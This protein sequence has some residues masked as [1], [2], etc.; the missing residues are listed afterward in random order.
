MTEKFEQIVSEGHEPFIE[1]EEFDI[2]FG[3]FIGDPIA[4]ISMLRVNYLDEYPEHTEEMAMD[5]INE[6][7]GYLDHASATMPGVDSHPILG[8]Y[9]A[10][11]TD[12]QT[13]LHERTTCIFNTLKSAGFTFEELSTW[14]EYVPEG[15][16]TSQQFE[17]KAD[18]LI[19][20]NIY[21][22]K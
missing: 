22:R 11:Y 17:Y 21:G 13:A 9:F 6:M 10:A 5:I 14:V 1:K 15:V 18:R 8:V 4:Y 19:L 16:H 2:R 20:N 12:E 7:F 3:K